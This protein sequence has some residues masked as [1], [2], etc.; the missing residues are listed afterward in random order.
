ML[1]YDGIK[2]SMLWALGKRGIIKNTQEFSTYASELQIDILME[3][4]ARISLFAWGV[5]GTTRIA[6]L[7]AQPRPPV[8]IT[9]SRCHPNRLYRSGIAGLVPQ[10]SSEHTFPFSISPGFSS[11]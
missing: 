2:G 8:Q 6:S 5:S 1:A 11:W 9:A 3:Q 10:D 7:A 4:Q